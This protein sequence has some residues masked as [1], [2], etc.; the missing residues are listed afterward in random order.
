M[1]ATS[2]YTGSVVCHSWHR[3]DYPE[4]NLRQE[5]ALSIGTVFLRLALRSTH[6]GEL[7][8]LR[9]ADTV[10]YILFVFFPLPFFSRNLQIFFN[11]KTI[12]SLS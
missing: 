10:Y 5:A 8:M 1:E 2:I 9:W 4:S 11:V 7:S 12:N 6:S 3:S